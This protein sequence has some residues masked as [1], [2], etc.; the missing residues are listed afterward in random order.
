MCSGSTHGEKKWE[1]PPVASL[2]QPMLEKPEESPWSRSPISSFLSAEVNRHEWW[3]FQTLL[4]PFPQYFLFLHALEKQVHAIFDL[5]GCK[6]PPKERWRGSFGGQKTTKCPFLCWFSR[7]VTPQCALKTPLRP[8][9]L[10]NQFCYNTFPDLSLVLSSFLLPWH[11]KCETHPM[12]LCFSVT[13]PFI[14]FK[15]EGIHLFL[16]Y[17][18]IAMMVA[19]L[20][21]TDSSLAYC[22]LYSI[23][24]ASQVQCVVFVEF[25][26]KWGLSMTAGLINRK[27]LLFKYSYTSIYLKNMEMHVIIIKC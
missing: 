18:P 26:F 15:G 4:W 5:S 9:N 2:I 25:H 16:G 21:I 6:A 3:A 1:K 23:K 11:C 8:Q 10:N 13:L 22:C 24:L 14:F 20:V 27:L 7:Y 19:C 12:L 17:L